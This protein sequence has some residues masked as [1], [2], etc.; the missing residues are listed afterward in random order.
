[1][2]SKN[3]LV[4]VTGVVSLAVLLGVGGGQAVADRDGMPAEKAG[5]SAPQ[6]EIAIGAVGEILANGSQ[7]Q[8]EVAVV[9]YLTYAKV[10]EPDVKHATPLLGPDDKVI[11]VA[12]DGTVATS[13]IKWAPTLTGDASPYPTEGNATIV[14]FDESGR[15][16]SRYVFFDRRGNGMHSSVTE[17][18]AAERLAELPVQSMP[19]EA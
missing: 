17:R 10:L 14:A 3:K 11:V 19:V 8:A 16:I 2:K 13:D 7:G 4:K 18:G 9:D 5:V 15:M 12:F 6:M 1:M